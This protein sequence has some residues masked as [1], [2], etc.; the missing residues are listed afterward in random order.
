MTPAPINPAAAKQFAA[1]LYQTH[2]D[3][4]LAAYH[5]SAFGATPD[6][7][8]L[9][10]I[11]DFLSSIGSGVS[12]AVSSVGSFL[13]NSDNLKTMAGLASSYL[14]AQTQQNVVNAQLARLQQSKPPVPVQYTQNSAGQYVPVVPVASSGQMVA[15]S[16]PYVASYVPVSSSMF[17]T[18]GASSLMQYAPWIAVAGLGAL[19]LLRRR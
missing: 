14:S 3:L 5:L 2:P 12:D 16:S 7:S 1:W 19:F 9:G 13:T 11:S 18:G 8:G 15:P 10:D 4:F 6:T 17:S